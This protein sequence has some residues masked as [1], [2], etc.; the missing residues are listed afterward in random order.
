MAAAID[1]SARNSPTLVS[2][3][4]AI[5]GRAPNNL[6]FGARPFFMS[7]RPMMMKVSMLDTSRVALTCAGQSSFAFEAAVHEWS[8]TKQ[9]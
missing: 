2:P 3:R 7:V 6:K 5:Q 9:Q 1:A 4:A 8:V